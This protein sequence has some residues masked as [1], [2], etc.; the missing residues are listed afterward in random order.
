VIA[1]DQ[2]IYGRL[3]PD[4]TLQALGVAV[5][6]VHKARVPED[7][8]LP[9]GAVPPDLPLTYV[10]PGYF[11]TFG[12]PLV[13]GRTFERLD[14]N[15]PSDEAVISR[16]LAERYWK[17]TSPIGKRLR[18][19]L[20]GPWF[21]IVGVAEDVHMQSLD[22]PPE[23][24]IYFSIAR[25]DDDGPDVPS[26]VALAIRTAGDPAAITP[27]LRNVFRTIDPALPTYDERPMAARLAASAARTRFVMLMLGV[28]S[29]VALVIGMVG[30]YG[31]LAY[32]VTLRRR[33]IG[34]RMALGATARDVTLMVARRGIV[35][36]A[37]GVGAG[38][39][40]ALAATRV[41]HGLLYG[42]SP[43]DPVALV[44]TCVTLFAVAAT[45]SWLPARRAAAI[46]PMEAL[47]RD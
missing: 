40:G 36:A 4:T 8:P 45:A 42:V 1:L 33:E 15:R 31:V 19:G 2:A 38:L 17:G 34:V 9:A 14:I 16:S 29:L 41:L 35:L 5:G 23:E 46:Q 6:N 7:Q 27:G 22:R 43:T 44:L 10:S 21:T 28:A 39:L 11:A 25:V 12:I 24:L 32:G 30:L 13:T 18:P 26:G 3:N 47:R 20:D 37:L